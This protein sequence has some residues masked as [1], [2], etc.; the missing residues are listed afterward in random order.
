MAEKGIEYLKRK[1]TMKQSRVRLRYGF[2]DMKNH[3][4]DIKGIIPDR[5][6]WISASL[7]W[8]AKGVDTLANRIVFDGFDHD[9][10]L[11]GDIYSNNNPDILCDDAV[12]SSLIGSCSFIYIGRDA[13][14]YPTMQVIDGSH[15]TGEI[16]RVTNLLTEGY[17]VLEHD[18]YDKPVLEAYFRPYRTDYYRN[19][20]LAPEMTM[21]HTA[22]YALLVPM[23][24]RPDAMR[25]FGHSRISRCCMDTVKAA[26][27]TM[28]RSEV[29]SEFYSFPQ[30][31]VLGLEDDAARIEGDDKVQAVMS[32]F[33]DFRKDS[34]GGHPTVGQFDQQSMAPFTEQLRTLAAV[35]AGET[36]LTLEDLGFST[37]NPPSYDAI[38]AS[39]ENLRLTA[40]KAQRT[41]GTG[42]LNA[43]YLA[44]CVRDRQTYNRDTFRDIKPVWMPIFEPDAATLGVIGD[45]ILKINQAS[46]GFL[47][48]RNIKSLTGLESDA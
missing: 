44:A 14:G 11:L 24:Y 9:D 4:D 47:G 10:F 19:G 20:R 12:L 40:R 38:R 7:G 5:L 34:N 33:L 48:S 17:A 22:P 25:P 32:A 8:C 41:F 45:A 1:L 16:D 6:K 43:G 31:Y 27:R 35:F 28:R 26:I 3:V 46:E 2:Y 15:A 21:E 36:D 23:I 30:R 29:S 42:F 13:S 18:E 37:G 39:H